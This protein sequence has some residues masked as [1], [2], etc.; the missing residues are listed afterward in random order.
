MSLFDEAIRRE[1][2]KEAQEPLFL[3]SVF[4]EEADED[5]KIKKILI[6]CSIFNSPERGVLEKYV[7]ENFD[8]PFSGMYE[9]PYFLNLS[10]LERENPEVFRTIQ[11]FQKEV[12]KIAESQ[13]PGASVRKEVE[14]VLGVK[15][16]C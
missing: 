15:K 14:G 16:G 1:E 10:R 2:E 5:L 13:L 11:N 3:T 6:G 9:L 12:F 4:S 8:R 7:S